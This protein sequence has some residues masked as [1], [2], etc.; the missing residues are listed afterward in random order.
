MD[1]EGHVVLEPEAILDTCERH[2]R[3]KIIKEFLI[4]W[5]NL[6]DEDAM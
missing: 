3:N 6:L 1:D 2:L 4:R 5:R